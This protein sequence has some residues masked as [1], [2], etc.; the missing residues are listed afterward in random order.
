MNTP[1]A[2]VNGRRSPGRRLRF[3]RVPAARREQGSTAIV[4][5]LMTGMVLTTVIAATTQVSLGA[6]RSAADDATSARMLLG[7][8]S[9][10]AR[11][12][13]CTRVGLYLG[14]PVNAATLDAALLGIP[15]SSGTLKTF[16]V[17]GATVTMKIV[18]TVPATFTSVSDLTAVDVTA[19][20][21]NGTNRSSVTQRFTVSRLNLPRITVPGAV[22]S[23]PG[24]DLN[25]NASIGGADVSLPDSAVYSSFLS[26]KRLS[27][28]SLTEG[29]PVVMDSSASNA[30]LL[31]SLLPGSYV[32]MPLVSSVT[33]LA[34]ATSPIGTF[35]V[36]A[37]DS[38]AQTVTLTPTSL[39]GSLLTPFLP[40]TTGADLVLNALTAV[41]ATSMTVNNSET[42]VQGDRVSVT[43]GV[44]AVT[45][46]AT[47]SA[48][49]TTAMT[50]STTT[51]TT[52]AVTGWSPAQPPSAALTGFRLGQPVS[53]ST[54]GVV[55]AGTFN[56]GKD[57]PVGGVM[58][59]A[60][61]SIV[62]SPLNDTLFTKTFGTTPDGLKSV[63]RV[64]DESQFSAAGRTVSGVTWLDSTTHSINLNSNPKL[65][66]TGVLVVDGDLTINQTQTSTCDM[67]GLLYVRGNLRIQG[68]LQLCG[69]IVVEGSVLDANDQVVAIDSTDTSFLGTGRKIQYDAK[70][71]YDITQ[72]T[73]R[74][75]FTPQSGTWRQQ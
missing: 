63:A 24:V 37:T 13:D 26:L 31:R 56:P 15:C 57:T 41:S 52:F 25:G 28:L 40:L 1:D 10:M 2:D 14:T 36:E 66:G 34:G 59:L 43:L 72:G 8:E 45:Y 74:L 21:T 32:R 27:P 53:K 23:Y 42:F 16:L 4:T 12:L 3:P 11:F 69:A 29:T 35:R 18:R 20:S 22:T 75:A 61:T 38:A 17:T 47:V 73:G 46:T 48:M 33:G 6:R 19:T 50:G 58:Q 64:L 5:V 60:S 44:P 7:A 39:P 62:P 30:R 71:L 51:S 9:G 65:N 68:N 54:L 67:S 70:V 49:P 55:T